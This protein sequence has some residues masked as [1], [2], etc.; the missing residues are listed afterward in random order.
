GMEAT[1]VAPPPG[2]PDPCGSVAGGAGAVG[3]GVPGSAGGGVGVGVLGTMI[4]ASSGDAGGAVIFTA[5][6]GLMSVFRSGLGGT[7]AIC[8]GASREPAGAGRAVSGVAGEPGI[9]NGPGAGLVVVGPPAG[10]VT[11]LP[12]G[13]VGA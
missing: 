4:D 12:P 1:T 2:R 13:C 10:G 5:V 7:A 9:C 3:A 8:G 6:S 11:E